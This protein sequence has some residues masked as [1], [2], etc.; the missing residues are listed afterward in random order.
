MLLTK[1]AVRP[2]RHFPA[3]LVKFYLFLSKNVIWRNETSDLHS[4][5]SFDCSL[6]FDSWSVVVMMEPLSVWRPFLRDIMKVFPQLFP[7]LYF[8]GY[9]VGVGSRAGQG[10]C[11]AGAIFTGRCQWRRDGKKIGKPTSFWVEACVN[12]WGLQ[13]M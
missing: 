12:V 3:T 9:G 1:K 6:L 5:A 8:R 4:Q 11:S 7:H 13:V 2:E 10:V